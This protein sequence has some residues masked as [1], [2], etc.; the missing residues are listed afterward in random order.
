MPGLRLIMTTSFIIVSFLKCWMF[1][2]RCTEETLAAL[3]YTYLNFLFLLSLDTGR[4]G[5]KD[6]LQ[7]AR[8]E[9]EGIFAAKSAPAL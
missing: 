5:A 6:F 3:S 9:D 1:I 8:I 7:P 4:V 2:N